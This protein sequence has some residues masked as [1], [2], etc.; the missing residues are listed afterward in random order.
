MPRKARE[1]NANEVRQ[2]TTPGRHAVGGVKGLRI[3]VHAGSGSKNWVLVYAS[4]ERRTT[5]SGQ[6]YNV[7][8]M[9]GL[10][11]YPDVS[12][13]EARRRARRAL[14]KL[15]DGIDPIEDRRRRGVVA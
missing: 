8:R 9:M 12:L 13:G 15:H 3:E 4:K 2:I 7:Q 1:L 6:A 5:A 14:A 10:G 11:G